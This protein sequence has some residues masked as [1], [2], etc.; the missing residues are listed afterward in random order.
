MATALRLFVTK[1][2][3]ATSLKD[4]ADELGITK[5]ALYYHFPAKAD[6][7]RSIFQPFI[8]DVDDLLDRLDGRGESP[9][10]ILSAYIDVLLPHRAALAAMLRDPGAAADL[11]LTDVSGRWL[12]RLGALLETDD[13]TPEARMRT[14]VAIGGA[15]RAL[16]LPEVEDPSARDAAVRAAVAALESR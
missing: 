13:A 16:M 12:A 9:R 11:D 14:T 7:A 2:F 8:D 15:T 10:E 4:I 6:L 3:S 1:G 5:A